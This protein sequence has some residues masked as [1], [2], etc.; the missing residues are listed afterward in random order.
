LTNF[1][2]KKYI[3]TSTVKPVIR[4]HCWDK[5]KVAL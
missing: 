1:K 2:D 3:Y 5:D 4:G